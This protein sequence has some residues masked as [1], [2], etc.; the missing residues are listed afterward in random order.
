MADAAAAIRRVMVSFSLVLMLY[1][2][3]FRPFIYENPTLSAYAPA[4]YAL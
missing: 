4:Y 2:E 1:F 3:N